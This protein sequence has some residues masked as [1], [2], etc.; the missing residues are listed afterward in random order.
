MNVNDPFTIRIDASQCTSLLAGGEYLG[1][2]KFFDIWKYD[3][4][5][6]E[7]GKIYA[8][9]GEHGEG[10]MYLSYLLGGKIDFDKLRIYINEDEIKKS[11]L[12]LIGWNL[13]P[14][15]E[16]YGNK[17]I[18]KSI[19][20]ALEENNTKESFSDIQEKFH[21]K[22]SRSNIKLKNLSGERWRACAALGYAKGRKIFYA[23][24]MT[25]S[26][27]YNMCQSGLLKVLRELANAEAIVLLPVGS[28]EFVKHIVDQCIYVKPRSY[29]IEDLER[30]IEQ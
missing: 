28:D 15:E 30:E 10:C 25:S 22:P 21:L 17:I 29:H 13:E 26:F 5:Q 19:L 18:K 3:N 24:Y 9:V 27:Y 8:L 23:P 1:K 12:Q 6:F 7:S 11:D 20:K 16:P 4:L 14:G 2:Q